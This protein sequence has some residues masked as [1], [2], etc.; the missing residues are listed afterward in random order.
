[1]AERYDGQRALLQLVTDNQPHAIAIVDR[2]GRYRFANKVA[3]AQAGVAPAEM[4]GKSVAAVLGPAAAERGTELDRAALAENR[5]VREVFRGGANGTARIVQ[6]SR[7]PVPGPSGAPDGVLVVEEDITAAVTER[8]RRERTLRDLVS[9]LVRLVDRRDPYAGDHSNRVAQVARAIA[10]EMGA[11]PVT[12]ETA[13]TAGKLMNLGK[14]LVPPELLTRP[15]SLSG[16]ELRQVHESL[17]QAADFL[18]GIE[19]DGPVVQ[20]LRQLRERWDGAGGPR[21]LAG[22]A[23]VLPARI[24]AVANAFVA[25]VSPRAFRAGLGFD[26]ASDRLLADAGRAFDRRV[27]TALLNRLDNRG[28]RAEWVRFQDTPA[29]E[30]QGA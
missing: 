3:A 18:S 7:V 1:L 27:V 14:I 23:I 24:V 5:I 8:E 29:T 16:D 21:G 15:G 28:G 22:D 30:A 9:S 2:E 6:T 25:M 11:D 10:E 4:L 26:A 12:I 13:E 19:F 17:G 20:T